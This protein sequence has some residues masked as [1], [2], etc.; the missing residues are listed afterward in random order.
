MNIAV[1]GSGGREHAIV[2]KLCQHH[3]PDTI[4]FLPGNP[5]FPH[6]YSLNIADFHAVRAFCVEKEIELVIVGSEEPLANG[7]VDSF[8]GS[9]IRVFGPKKEA[10][11]LESSKIFAKNFM[12]A[13]GVATADFWVCDHVEE[14]KRR[15]EELDGCCVIK[16]DGLAGGKGVSVCSSIE[17]AYAALHWQQEK[18][19][20][21]SPFLIEEKL[22]GRELSVF[23][24]TDGH[25]IKLLSPAQD[26]KRAY[27]DD[28][29]PNTG[30][31]GAYCPVSYDESITRCIIE[32]TMEG[33]PSLGY[34]G[35]VYF[36]IMMT[37]RGP[38]LLEYNVR[39]G[40]PEAEVTLPALKTDL[41]PLINA[42]F[43]GT[44]NEVDVEFY[45]GAFVDVVLTSQGYPGPIE[46]GKEIVGLEKLLD[47]TLVFHA[48][49]QSQDNKLVTSG[50]R[51]LNIV[52]HGG[53]LQEAADNVYRE[54]QKVN[55]EGITYRKDIGT[56]KGVCV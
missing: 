1:I 13:H 51:V 7:I 50:G 10:A 15:I 21:E 29:G 14:A 30:G 45:S 41:L 9:G 47:S 5:G 20:E 34:C 31:M 19:G 4:F 56:M 38:K 39:L 12:K 35:V 54:C 6:S 44:L 22:Q 17:E 27:E 49:T 28:E 43:E 3:D 2:W 16:Y 55:F 11:R 48:G 40:D 8:S 18:Y 26:H 42:C 52:C 53:D 33:L 37:D 46:V 23:G 32:P 24:F 25:D 36:G